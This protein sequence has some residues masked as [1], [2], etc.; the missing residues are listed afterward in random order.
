MRRWGGGGGGG[1]GGFTAAAAGAAGCGG[2]NAGLTAAFD[3]A[4]D[5]MPLGPLPV[6][7]GSGGGG[8]GGGGGGLMAA[9][10]GGDREPCRAQRVGDETGIVG[11]RSERSRPVLIIADH[12]R[13]AQLLGEAV[14]L[15]EQQND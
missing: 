8:G 9:F 11:W 15:T 14:V 6:P 13:E 12:Q 5:E 4:L 2:G 7:P 3:G 1:E 10:D